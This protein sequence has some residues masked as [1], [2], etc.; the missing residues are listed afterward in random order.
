M[1][2]LWRKLKWLVFFLGHGLFLSLRL[3]VRSFKLRGCGRDVPK[4][5]DY[6][7]NCA[8]L[9]RHVTCVT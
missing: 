9:K 8:E 7:G 4:P 5:E 6:L 2:K 3:Y 1:A